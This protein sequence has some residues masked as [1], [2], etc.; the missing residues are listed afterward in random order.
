MHVFGLQGNSEKPRN[1]GKNMQTPHSVFQLVG[2]GP[3]V[4]QRAVL[5]NRKCVDFKVFVFKER[6][7]WAFI[8]QDT[9]LNSVISIIY[10]QE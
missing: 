5:I 7:Y 9:L 10:L 8:L 4:G 3:K 2:Y 6:R 1:H